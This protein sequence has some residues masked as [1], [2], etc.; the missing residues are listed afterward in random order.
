MNNTY[1]TKDFYCSAFLVASGQSIISHERLDGVSIFS[2]TKSKQVE[3]LTN[4]Y[5]GFSAV[6]NPV[7]YAAACK[8][9]KNI[10]YQNKITTSNSNGN[11]I[12]QQLR[13]V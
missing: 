2:F 5:Y 8:N 12:H 6:I 4:N 3:E 1:D 10:M 11:S 7:S 9:L 13:K